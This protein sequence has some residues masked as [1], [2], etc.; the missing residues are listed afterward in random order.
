MKTAEEIADDM[1]REL[2]PALIQPI[3]VSNLVSYI[4]SIQLDAMK[5]GARRAADC[6]ISDAL[7]KYHDEEDRCL[8]GSCA[9]RRAI[10]TTAEQW[11][12]KDL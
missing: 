7:M 5:E 4:E 2:L 12:E 1:N 9:A 6:A 3:K 8:C 11:T 10:L